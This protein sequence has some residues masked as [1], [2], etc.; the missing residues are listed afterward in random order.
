[1]LD[2]N[3][4]MAKADRLQLSRV[5]PNASSG[6]IQTEA[7]QNQRGYCHLHADYLGLS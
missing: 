4:A 6:V 2:N 1:V 7:G 5:I 3:E